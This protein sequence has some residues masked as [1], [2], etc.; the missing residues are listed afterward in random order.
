[1]CLGKI[2]EPAE[3]VKLEDNKLLREQQGF[4][5]GATVLLLHRWFSYCLLAWEHTDSF[6]GCLAV[7]MRR[8]LP[9][10]AAHT[11]AAGQQ[12]SRWTSADI[13][14]LRGAGGACSAVVSLGRD[15]CRKTHAACSFKLTGVT[16]CLISSLLPAADSM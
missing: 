9:L 16:C 12:L 2:H 11:A 1:M 10:R 15:Q 8:K 14:I 3:R 7:H 5:V 6:L 13:A 4:R